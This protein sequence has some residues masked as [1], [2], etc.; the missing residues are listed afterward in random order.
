MLNT[1]PQRHPKRGRALLRAYGEAAT[2]RLSLNPVRLASGVEEREVVFA[3]AAVGV[4]PTCEHRRLVSWTG[5][6]D[7]TDLEE[8]AITMPEE[9][10]SEFGAIALAALAIS[11]FEQ[12]E[13]LHVLPKGSGG[14]YL[15]AVA[16]RPTPIQL[17]VS[18]IRCDDSSS[19]AST[20]AR[21]AAKCE[22]VLTKAREGFVSVTTFDHRPS[23]GPY[24]LLGYVTRATMTART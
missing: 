13:I 7:P 19:G 24:T 6:Y 8:L 3:H 15:I 4:N 12:A 10:V 23:G 20:T 18:G 21:V 14:D 22:Q 11:E 1:L 16:W 2:V 5:L 9:T 17:E